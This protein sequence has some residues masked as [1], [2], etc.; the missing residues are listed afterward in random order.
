MPRRHSDDGH[1]RGDPGDTGGLA[2][3]AHRAP[4][5]H[6][7]A[8]GRHVSRMQRHAFLAGISTSR[9]F[10]ISLN[11]KEE[12]TREQDGKTRTVPLLSL[13]LS[14]YIVSHFKNSRLIRKRPDQS[15]FQV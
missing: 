13:C 10:Y 12:R 6:R 9:N 15:S 1:S 11:K 8:Q 4:G 3:E 5:R 7:G 14:S 2:A